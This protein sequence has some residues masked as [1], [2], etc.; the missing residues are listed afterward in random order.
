MPKGGV[1]SIGGE[2]S[3]SS[4]LPRCFSFLNA[5]A[6]RNAP[7]PSVN[8]LRTCANEGKTKNLRVN[9]LHRSSREEG[10]KTERKR[11]N[12]VRV[13]ALL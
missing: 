13:G 5:F 4:T 2:D 8:Q 11:R 6:F 9:V 7:V 12:M 1:G 3:P 10:P